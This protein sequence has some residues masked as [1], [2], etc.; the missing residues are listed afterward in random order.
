M[1]GTRYLSAIPVV[2]ADHH[3]RKVADIP[4][5]QGATTRHISGNLEAMRHDYSIDES[6]SDLS[7]MN[8][9]APV[10]VQTNIA[11]DRAVAVHWPT[12]SVTAFIRR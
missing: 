5:L 4:R 3:V 7:M 8:V 2:N 10:D 11:N 9:V 12:Q 1:R 6:C